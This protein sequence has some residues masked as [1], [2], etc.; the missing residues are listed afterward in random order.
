M[1]Q[2]LQLKL[3]QHLTMTP[4]LQQAIRLLQLSTLELH[5]EVQEAL[6]SNMMLEVD[7]EHEPVNGV[8]R[9]EQDVQPV[10]IPDELPTD[11]AWEDIYETPVAS[12]THAGGDG[13][14]MDFENQSGDAETLHD[15]LRWQIALT[16]FSETDYL[17]AEAIVDAIDDDG[18]LGQSLEE[19]HEMLDRDSEQIELDEVEAVLKQVQNF[20]PPGIG[21]RDLKECLL[22]QLA[23]YH[24]KTKWRE[25]AIQLVEQHLDLL[26]SHEYQQLMRR[27]GVTREQLTEIVAFI[28]SLHPRPGGQ[29]SPPPSQYVVPDVFVRKKNGT[30]TVETQSRGLTA[31]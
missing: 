8:D 7:E 27:L 25:E 18:Y 21:A 11:S 14:A 9:A 24:P 28:Q 15:H 17:I 19:I 30:W 22:L 20:D 3:G 6:E 2:T 29:I 16:N 4:Q 31:A 5:T 12:F 10:D 23:Q 1:K 13:I 26:A